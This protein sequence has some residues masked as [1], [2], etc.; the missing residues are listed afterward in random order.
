MSMDS[1]MVQRVPNMID[2]G[3]GQEE[4]VSGGCLPDLMYHPAQR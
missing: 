1:I 3:L 2:L 4:G